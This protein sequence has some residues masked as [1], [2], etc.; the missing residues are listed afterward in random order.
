MSTI[1]FEIVIPAAHPCFKSADYNYVMRADGLFSDDLFD[2]FTILFIYIFFTFSG[3]LLL[4]GYQAYLTGLETGI[5]LKKLVFDIKN[6]CQK[7]DE[8]F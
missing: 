6:V 2:E 1:H 4:I 3:I 5:Q 8:A 7:S